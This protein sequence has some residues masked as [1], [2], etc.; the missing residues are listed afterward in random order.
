MMINAK[1][2]KGSKTKG[3]EIEK[4]WRV[5]CADPPQQMLGPAC[6]WK[7]L[8]PLQYYLITKKT[9]RPWSVFREGQQSSEGSGAQTLWE[10]AEGTG[11][12]QSGEEGAQGKP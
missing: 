12:V 11:I 8:S 6:L 1:S 2:K 4:H 7:S 10:V 5:L 3:N 9:L